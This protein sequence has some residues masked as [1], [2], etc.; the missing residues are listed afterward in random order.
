MITV[1]KILDKKG[2]D[3]FKLSPEDSVMEAL[4]IMDERNIGALA[5][6][7]GDDIYGIFSER[8]YTRRVYA[9]GRDPRD[10][11][12]KEV[13]TRDVLYAKPEE[14]CEQV[15]Y[16]MSK[17]DIRHMPVIKEDHQ[18]LG[19]ISIGDIAREVIEGQKVQ[20]HNLEHYVNWAERY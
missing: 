20:I 15:L 4:K 17:H 1:K 13:M 9:L 2:T 14:H 18:V 7:K 6:M 8:D 3:I 12:L 10:I 11:Q 16:V 19:M 5:V